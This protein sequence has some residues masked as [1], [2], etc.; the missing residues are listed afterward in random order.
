MQLIPHPI[1]FFKS[2]AKLGANTTF[3]IAFKDVNGRAN[4]IVREVT[5]TE[6]IDEEEHFEK[7]LN[8]NDMTFMIIH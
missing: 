1:P 5:T 8:L 2:T 7:E 3:S 4:N 6:K